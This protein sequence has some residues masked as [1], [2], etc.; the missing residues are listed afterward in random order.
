MFFVIVNALFFLIEF[1]IQNH[2]IIDEFSSSRPLHNNHITSDST[3]SIQLEKV[4]IAQTHVLSPDNS[5]FQLVSGKDALLKINLSSPGSITAPQMSAFLE[6][7]GSSIQKDLAGPEIIPLYFNSNV[8]EVIHK[9]EDSYTVLIEGGWIQPGL[10]ISIIIGDTT[11]NYHDLSIGAPNKI[12]MN[13]FDVHFFSYA[14]SNDYP[15]GWVEELENKW[16]V[17]SIELQRYSNLIFEE[18]SVPPRGNFVAARVSSKQEYVDITGAPN[19]DGEQAAALQWVVAL[20]KAA[21]IMGRTSLDYVNIYGVPSGGQACCFY[22]VGNGTGEGILHHELGHSFSLPHWGNNSQY[23][24]KGDMHGIL[25]PPAAYNGTHAGPTWAF[26]IDKLDFIPPTVQEYD[27]S[28]HKNGVVIGTYKMDPMQGGGFGDQDDGYML[29]HFSDYSVNKM[30]NY[31]ENELVLWSDSLNS[32]VKWNHSSKD[33]SLPISNNGVNYPIERNVEVVSV[34]AGVSSTTPQANIIYDPIGP[35]T[36]ALIEL[37]D[38][39]KAVDRSKAAENYCP[40]N[41]CDATLR[42][43]QNGNTNYYLLPVSI[44]STLNPLSASSFTTRAINLR[45]NDGKISEVQLLKTPDAETN[46]LPTNPSILAEYIN[47]NTPPVQGEVKVFILAGQSNMSGF[48]TIEPTDQNIT[49]NNGE[50]T[51]RFLT[52][53]DS[54]YNHLIDTNNNWTNR[55]DV[56]VVDLNKTG[57]LSVG[58]GADG[59]YFGP[60]LQ[61]GHVLGDYYEDPVLII[62]TAW[63]GKSLA[64]DFRPPSSSG[65]T[66]VYYTEMINRIN[67]V[68][69]N[70]GEFVP[71]YAELPSKIIGFGW[72]QGW[73]DRIDNARNAEYLENCVNLINDLRADFSVPDMPFV[74]A[75]TGMHGWSETH[76]RALSLMEAQLAVPNDERL[77]N[78]GNVF[79]IETRD[80]WRDSEYSPSEQGYHWNRNAETLFL[81]GNSMGLSMVDLITNPTTLENPSTQ[82]PI[83]YTLSQNY[84]NPFNPSTV[85]SYSLS[86][87]STVELSIYDIMGKKVAILVNEFK[88]AGMY[89][90]NFNA[91]DLSSGIYMYQLKIDGMVVETR[92][93]TLIK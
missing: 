8:G 46:G 39:Q 56:W 86:T 72:H 79:T 20:K 9:F 52:Q 88:N 37:Y 82:F 30:Q 71:S 60:E 49:K 89:D 59:N 27:G 67:D 43:I 28:N 77:L 5:L 87:N 53:Q 69:H 50:G 33:Y 6:L 80:F 14:G 92:S 48:G 22:G 45:A 70:L 26:D 12:V 19:F 58:F 57:P 75:T 65:D 24:Y 36:S 62:K 66:G 76:H 68:L 81:I 25:A 11:Y 21:G 7:N 44:D 91:S 93:M 4:Y 16:P 83:T 17:S 42:V 10:K 38:P 13:M 31:I 90:V 34:M 74:L 32:Y 51:L 15:S 41:G 2:Q 73:N 64:D 29:R 18:L 35:Y 61:F 85:I 55:N 84:P 23:P 1:N 47:V 3:H 40:H 54:S 78:S 63:G